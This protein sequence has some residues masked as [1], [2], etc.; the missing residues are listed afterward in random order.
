MC[1]ARFNDHID[2]EVL[3]TL[4][5]HIPVEVTDEAAIR[6]AVKD[7]ANI[8]SEC[9]AN[10][11]RASSELEKHKAAEHIQAALTRHRAEAEAAEQDAAAQDPLEE[12]TVGGGDGDV[13]TRRTVVFSRLSPREKDKFMQFLVRNRVAFAK[14]GDEF[15]AS[16]RLI[17]K[18]VSVPPNLHDGDSDSDSVDAAARAPTRRRRNNGN[19]VSKERQYEE[20]LFGKRRPRPPQDQARIVNAMANNNNFDFDLADYPKYTALLSRDGT[21]QARIRPLPWLLRTIEDIYEARFAFDKRRIDAES[22]DIDGTGGISEA[23]EVSIVFPVFT[24]D[25]FSRK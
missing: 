5:Q 15:V 21:H 1:S 11:A 14:T 13:A 10:Y 16:I 20:G 22:D 8:V 18:K 3:D 23:D 25:F 9:L 24:V 12:R 6:Y 7:L 17:P 19:K 4:Q 2:D